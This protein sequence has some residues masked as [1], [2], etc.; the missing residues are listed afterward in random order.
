VGLSTIITVSRGV[1]HPKQQ[2][3]ID[4]P[5]SGKGRAV[6]VPP[7]IRDDLRRHMDTYVEKDA[8]AQL[9]PAVKGGCHLNDRVFR[10]YFTNALKSIR[11][12][13]VRV[14]DLRHFAGTQKGRVANLVE[15]MAR[16]RQRRQGRAHSC[17]GCPTLLGQLRWFVHR[18]AESCRR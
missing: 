1:T 14:H 7:H 5:K 12:D 11:R 4:T 3:R 2:C 9:F 17:V 8:G 6:V 16:Y 10:D 15:T 13:S 18:Q